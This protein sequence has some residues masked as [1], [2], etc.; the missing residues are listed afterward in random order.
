M[1]EE[2]PAAASSMSNGPQGWEDRLAGPMFFLAA[3]FLVILAGLLHRYPRV[4]VTEIELEVF[5]WGIGLTWLIVALE[6]LFRV[7]IRNRQRSPWRVAGSALLIALVPPLRLGARS[8]FRDQHI[9]LPRLGWQPID[10]ELRRRLE[11]FF[12]IPMIII[13]LMVLPFLAIEYGRADEVRSEPA[14]A[15]FLDI[16]IGIIW[17]AFALEFVVMVSVAE[18]KLSYCFLHWIDLA[19]VLLPLVEV[20]PFLRMLRVGRV[21]R[22]EQLTRL[23][24]LYRLQGVAM[25]AWRAFLLLGVIQRLI[26]RSLENRLRQFEA[27]LEAKQDEVVQLRQEI[28]QLKEKIGRQHPL[29][30]QGARQEASKA[31]VMPVRQ[32]ARTARPS[33]APAAN[34][35]ADLPIPA[36]VTEA[37]DDP[38]GT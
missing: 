3:M 38:G 27:Q 26:S 2:N 4:G 32:A 21:L 15:L 8:Q 14:L 33:P 13:A 28:E 25:R 12:S 6:Q 20:L 22:A 23:S 7:V 19:I 36:I 17:L 9:W 10:A 31:T 37:P 30:D 29:Q 24:R 11:R 34:A 1:G 18:Q 35:V 16:G 5:T